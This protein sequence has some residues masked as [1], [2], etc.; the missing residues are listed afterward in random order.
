MIGG[1]SGMKK[2]NI[3]SDESGDQY[4]DSWKH[5]DEKDDVT[6]ADCISKGYTYKKEREDT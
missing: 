4:V 5:K 2:D 6:L 1:A 3:D